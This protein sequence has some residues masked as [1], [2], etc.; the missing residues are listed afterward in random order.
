MSKEN[1]ESIYPL[2]P[3]QEGMLFHSLTD[4]DS[5][6]YFEQY[7]CTYEGDFDVAAYQQA[8]ARVTE[9]HPILRT[10]VM[11]KRKDKS[12]QVVRKQV[13]LEWDVQDWRALPPDQIQQKLAAFLL[14]DRARGFDLT[15][16]PLMRFALFRLADKAYRFVWSFHHLLLDGWSGAL[17][18]NEV[19]AFYQAARD[20]SALQLKRARPYQ[21]YIAWLQKQDL[22]KAQ[23]FWRK[24]LEGFSSPTPLYAA[25]AASPDAAVRYDRRTI[26]LSDAATTALKSLARRH[27]LTL[28]TVVQ[29][30]WALL[31]SRY[32]GEDDV[33]FGATVS[34][35][36]ADLDGV[37]E[38]IGLFINT[39]PVRV[40]VPADELFIAWLQ[41]LQAQQL[42]LRDYEYSPLYLVQRWSEI[43][44]GQSLFES[45]VVFENFP[46]VKS[47]AGDRGFTIKDVY[48]HEETNFPLT[49]GAEPGD[50]LLL[51]INYDCSRFDAG[52]IDRL[53]GHF[54]ALL[55]RVALDPQQ[56]LRDI[57]IL[58]DIEQSQLLREWNATQADVPAGICA[59]QAFA[60]AA[61]AHPDAVA[62]TAPDG[63]LT[64]GELEQKADRLARHLRTRGVGPEVIVGVC[65]ERSLNLIVAILGI[66]KAGGAY[67]P[68][69]PKHPAER[70]VFMLE[71][72]AAP[73]IL[74]QQS[75]VGVVSGYAGVSLCLDRDWDAIAAA[76]PDTAL[77][78]VMPASLAY[79]IYTSGST[80]KPK[81]V[82]I[83]HAGLMNL[84][85]WHQRA[86]G[87][88]RSDRATMLAGLAFDA[89]VWELWP[90]ITAGASIHL[91]DEDVRLS[92]SKI[93]KWFADK[94]ITISFLPTPLAEAVLSEP[95]PTGLVLKY[96]LTGGDKL[97]SPPTRALPFRLH[98][99]YGPT[100]NTVVTTAAEI[101]V[102]AHG[103]LG[104]PTIGRPIAN[105]QVY[106]LDKFGKPV[107]IGIAGELHVS[108]AG[109]ARGYVNRSDLTR[110][111]FVPNPFDK[112]GESRMY[113]TGDLVRYAA[114]GNIEFLGRIDD[115]VKIHGYRIELGEIESVLSQYVGVKD[116]VVI[117]REDNPGEKKLVAYIV[118]A[119]NAALDQNAFR[120]YLKTKLPAY[121]VPAFLVPMAALPLT[122][123]GKVDRRALPA[124]DA[125][126]RVRPQTHAAPTSEV[127]KNLAAI[128]SA[129]LRVDN[130][131]VHDNFFELGGD[132][133]LSIQVIARAHQAN[134]HLSPKDI[135]QNPTIADLAQVADQ[136]R[137]VTAEQGA[138]TGPV[139]LTP[140]QAWFFEQALPVP[141]H[142]NQA[143]L[144]QLRPDVNVSF[145][146]QAIGKLIEHHDALRMRYEK[147]PEGWRQIAT[148][149]PTPLAF[150]RIDLSDVPAR[151]HAGAI[152]QRATSL[153]AGLSLEQ[154]KLLQ[155][156]YFD[157]GPGVSGRLL[158][159]VHHLV[160]DGVSW[161]ILLED[162]EQ[163]YG[164]LQQNL[165]V[166]LPPKTTSFKQWSEHLSA[167]ANSDAVVRELEF[168]TQA[169]AA[170][171]GAI[172]VDYPDA[173]GNTKSS[174]RSYAVQLDASD[175]QALLQ[176]VP[177]AYNT[178]IN[179]VLLTALARTLAQWTKRDVVAIDMEGHGR[180]DIGADL[181]TSRTVGWFT[182]LF[183]V[184]LRIEG[185]GLGPALCA[186]KEQL[187]RLPKRG[188][189]YGL[190]RY[191]H[192]DDAVRQRLLGS[193]RPDVLFNY[194][195]QFD[196]M[197][198]QSQLF[199]PAP[200][201]S[202]W[203]ED[204]SG[205]RSH[206]LEIN[207]LIVE[208]RLRVEWTF[209]ETIHKRS[210]IAKLAENYLKQL[211][212]LIAHCLRPGAGGFT[213]S[214]FPHA[215]MT[216]RQLELL[217]ATRGKDIEDI[218][219]LSSLQ[220][221]MLYHTLAAPEAGISLEQYTF[222]LR[223]DF[224]QSAYELAW[225]TVLDRHPALRG[226]FEWEGLSEPH[227]V[228]CRR[229]TTTW[230][231]QDWRSLTVT[232]QDAR[233]KAY[234]EADRTKGLD[235]TQAPLMR[236]ALLRTAEHVW[237]FVWSF[238]HILID[239]WSMGLVLNEV[240]TFYHALV[241]GRDPSLP[242]PKPYSAYIDWL[243]RQDLADA[244]AYW[245]KAL[246]GFT[247][248]SSLRVSRADDQ[249]GAAANTNAEQK[250]EL[251]ADTTAGLQAL[252]RQHGVTL[253]AVVQ[254]GWALLL[255]GYSGKDDVVFGATVSGRPSAIDGIEKMTGMF[256]NNLPVRVKIEPDMALAAWLRR[257]QERQLEMQ[258]Y[259]FTPLGQIQNWSE[260][261]RQQP[262]FESLL[263]F[264][265]YP[266]D[267]LSLPAD[268]LNIEHV[269]LKEKTN[270]PINVIAIP[271]RTLKIFITY[272]P[273]AY[274]PAVIAR[275]LDHVKNILEQMAQTPTTKVG[276]ISLLGQAERQK[277]LAGWQAAAHA[278]TSDDLVQHALA[279]GAATAPQAIAVVCGDERLTYQQLHQ[280]TN[281]LAHF[282][283]THGARPGAAVGLCVESPLFLLQGVLGVL[284]T[285]ATCLVVDPRD[286]AVRLQYAMS[287]SNASLMLTQSSLRQRL[288]QQSVPVVAI[289]SERDA[290]LKQA[291]DDFMI[292][293]ADEEPAFIFYVAGADGRPLGIQVPH[294]SVIHTLRG[295]AAVVGLVPTD[296]HVALCPHQGSRRVLEL[297]LPLSTNARL[298]LPPPTIADGGALA[299]WLPASQA[300]V[301]SA[302]PNR[303]RALLNAG[304]RVNA[305]LKVLS[306]G[307]PLSR[308]STDELV[309]RGVA[310][311]RLYGA[312]EAGT[313]S[314]CHRHAVAGDANLI[315]RVSANAAVYLLD[316]R[317][318]PVPIGV[319]GEIYV[320][321]PG[322]ADG[323][324]NQ[325]RLS[326]SRFV[327]VTD[328]PAPLFKT[329]D[330]ARYWPDGNIE[331]VGR[332]DDQIL[333]DGVRI[334]PGEIVARMVEHDAI[335]H[336]AVFASADSP[337]DIRVG[338]YY[339][340]RSGRELTVTDVRKHM[341]NHITSDFVAFD[342]VELDRFPL[343]TDGRVDQ[344]ALRVS[345]MASGGN[346][347][348]AVPVTD[349]EKRIA[350]IWQS[351]L[352]MEKVSLNDNFF[353]LGGH[354]LLA[355]QVI[356]DIE[357]ATGVRITA[358]ALLM[359]TLQ[360]I[361]MMCAA[362]EP[363]AP[364]RTWLDRIRSAFPASSRPAG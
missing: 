332:V 38:M 263:V 271:G 68:M 230:N 186:I 151:Q 240:V 167:Y 86:Y 165:A 269:D 329:G 35:R 183:P 354:S 116:A 1:I 144:L 111:M 268:R 112:S 241:D 272:D 77:P 33:V 342:F 295:V 328:L 95:M 14:A 87:V 289:D 287:D 34:G 31:L 105:T 107:P 30:G 243:S 236:F 262:L 192:R 150:V 194:L 339:S 198:S 172:P 221:G 203:S 280:H 309:S 73:M 169:T 238:H 277:I 74:T 290:I 71:D 146:E 76:S 133:I 181:D 258:K 226:A 65:L 218:Y 90:Y 216:G 80:G 279:Q 156:A 4:K 308:P 256:I 344:D 330:L 125:A 49:I 278:P 174:A 43:P 345:V 182:S 159:A 157:L 311:Y 61:R 185:A 353:E 98:N 21:D 40:R 53:L 188:I 288:P 67:L 228:V 94:K 207:A 126:Q 314:Q 331:Y 266:L 149:D 78:P 286:P 246:K 200:E 275:M 298:I 245:R 189:G 18:S 109:L 106:V 276:D 42:D 50:S 223:G 313:W 117:V 338:V 154:G 92:P 63:Q 232:E 337:D 270:Y 46:T 26:H 303:L 363:R 322:L 97:H 24:R 361:A 41:A 15:K 155:A 173:G 360:Q 79:V 229:A 220:Q 273:N 118:A 23:A 152:E 260:V 136:G 142:W 47:P 209:S 297:L 131:G 231:R 119:A 102:A 163:V 210:S 2:S 55:E 25:R 29:G 205:M 85:S 251:A 122:S 137:Q 123:N 175:T 247:A 19:F 139:P 59:H 235:L 301:L 351:L 259:E 147:R 312:E 306:S 176:K 349:I 296:V 237:Y 310:L 3:M 225:Q 254:G 22:T 138:V 250:L 255:S 104:P 212:Q 284:K 213:P 168:W 72:T 99:H 114:D 6:A 227:Q 320:G 264:E 56:K 37:E 128:F 179:D 129:V 253:N 145:L 362:P 115:Q 10:L 348:Y 9:R 135:F 13:E 28:N 318:R 292:A 217:Y 191:L 134:I 20:Q 120:L 293:S 326:E 265:N 206:L 143:Y 242:R 45:I 317:Q 222:R 27:Q 215:R 108:G 257:I 340:V 350:G 93:V 294:R 170:R 180:E 193:P 299:K 352:D 141:Q 364:T 323:Y 32:S 81:G 327:T 282:L 96:L 357:A 64:Y 103:A 197:L 57:D 101:P 51:R 178:Q 89:S 214:D 358:R 187:R 315:G 11:W 341:R 195:G 48:T 190:L 54:K 248:P 199:R 274:E 336:S 184:A 52:V 324:M 305:G 16:A 252:A 202:G 234:Q 66:L 283:S 75:L 148:S 132:S 196:Q 60:A 171:H 162:L 319:T 88:T 70:L 124:P 285:G 300:S 281:R 291:P 153:Q 130:V 267:E 321:G 201:S 333:F 316:A 219:P 166:R 8:W 69:D 224:D 161:R 158:I 121:M 208:G 335:A 160:V 177:S 355:M 91:A 302:T 334:E 346:A 113:R 100:E 140:I 204:M 84:V 62:V 307:E 261:A 239:G 211:R 304:W 12:L 83:A 82:A 359:N 7:Q 110:Q 244:E 164:Q 356:A 17:L 36:P 343:T 127:E 58:T 249:V 233:L 325:P 5:T 39:L 347:R 44:R